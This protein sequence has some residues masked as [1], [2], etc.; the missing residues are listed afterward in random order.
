MDRFKLLLI[1]LFMLV[2]ALAFNAGLNTASLRRVYTELLTA[3]FHVVGLD[4]HIK[5]ERAVRFGKLLNKFVGL[6]QLLSK[7]HQELPQGSRMQ[8]VLPDGTPIGSQSVTPGDITS[9]KAIVQWYNAQ[10][11]TL[12]SKPAEERLV[13]SH[14]GHHHLIFPIINRENTLAGHLVMVMPKKLI[15]KKVALVIREQSKV[16]GMTAFSAAVL[17]VLGLWLFVGAD[18][19]TAANKRRLYLLISIVLVGA[20][21]FFSAHSANLFRRENIQA[22]KAHAHTQTSLIKQDL[23]SKVLHKGIQINRLRGVEKRFATIIDANADI[24]SMQV[25]DPTGRILNM[26]DA[27]GAIDGPTLQ[28]QPLV[29]LTEA[30]FEILQPLVG[31]KDGQPGVTV[32]YLRTSVSQQVIGDRVRE[33]IFDSLTIVLLSILFILELEFLLIFFISKRQVQQQSLSSTIEPYRFARPAAFFFLFAWALPISFIPLKMQ[34]LYTPMAG[35]SKDV[36]LGLPISIEMLCAL[37]TA[38]IAGG[39]TDRHGW[40]VPFLLGLVLAAAGCYLSASTVSGLMFIVARGLAGLGYGFAWM[41]IQG[42]IFHTSAENARA[43][44]YSNLVAGIFSGH[45]CGTAAGAM[46]AERVGYDVVFL[47][48]TGLMIGP[49]LF[50]LMFMADYMKRPTTTRSLPA[51]K[52]SEFFQLITNRNF[53]AVMML[54]VV[55]FSICQV[56]LL[57]YA[58]PIYLNQLGVSQS[59]IG[60]VLMVYGLSVIFIAPLLSRLVD[61]AHRKAKFIILGG[62]IGAMGLISLYFFSGMGPVLAA[63]FTL[64]VSSSLAGSAQPALA[65][66]IKL[67]QKIGAGRSMSIQRAADKLG[68]MAGPVVV[69]LLVASIGIERSIAVSGIIFLG[70]TLLF[71]VLVR[72]PNK[73]DH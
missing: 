8:V 45:I 61:R 21:I 16:L 7:A 66:K 73:P 41:A 25:L 65:L 23:E 12:D 64:G 36:V 18:I 71:I 20:Q 62:L 22:A 35:L 47:A 69:G 1:S 10:R 31:K 27:S 17:L 34:L 11:P 37:V 50:I 38:L 57:Y 32:G 56:G 9:G 67:A 2:T 58:A 46:L 63:V 33:I 40:H 59:S 39:L 53:F 52:L 6:E 26:A 55:P 70:A 60:R 42:F 68:Q 51:M 43:K 29:A 19:E 49:L 15:E 54:S 3:Q 28:K 44:G 72:E 30:P 5:I 24:Q 4:A 14:G 13:F 48:S